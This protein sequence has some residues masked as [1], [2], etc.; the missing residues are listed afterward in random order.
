[1]IGGVVALLVLSILIGRSGMAQGTMQGTVGGCPVGS[2]EASPQASPMAGMVASS[3]ATPMAS[4]EATPCA[5][6]AAGA[7]TEVTIEGVDINW[8][9]KEVTIAA[10][11]DVRVILP[12]LGQAQHNFSIDALGISVDMPVGQTV[13]TK[14]N[15]PAGTY[16]YYCN[17]PGHAQAG[18]VGKLIVQ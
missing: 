1:M 2:P 11:T 13:E 7:A 9:Q 15:A 16:E 12:N 4:P 3:A 6:P 14:I 10:N 18:M 8:N 5:S 17:V